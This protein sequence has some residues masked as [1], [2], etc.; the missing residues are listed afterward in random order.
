MTP[1]APNFQLPPGVLQFDLCTL[2][3]QGIDSMV[4]HLRSHP[5]LGDVSEPR[6]R[7]MAIAFL[8]HG[9]VKNGNRSL[10]HGALH[11]AHLETHKT[12]E[13]PWLSSMRDE[14]IQLVMDV[15]RLD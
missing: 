7:A 12:G 10:P 8:A 15:V 3:P 1:S 5:L 2:T 14:Y 9:G 13:P 11:T 4:F 6:L